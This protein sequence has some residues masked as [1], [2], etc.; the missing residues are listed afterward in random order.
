M[1]F[2]P[3]GGLAEVRTLGVTVEVADRPRL[4]EWTEEPSP[5]RLPRHVA[6][7]ENDVSMKTGTAPR[8]R[9]PGR[10]VFLRGLDDPVSGCVL[11]LSTPDPGLQSGRPLLSGLRAG[12][13]GRL[14]NGVDVRVNGGG[15]EGHAVFN[16]ITPAWERTEPGKPAVSGLTGWIDPDGFVFA[17]ESQ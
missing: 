14:L 11:A 1:V 12:S 4:Q 8:E 17:D 2:A 9:Q 16:V 10:P 5:A 6:H 3:D 13:S 15:R 7:F